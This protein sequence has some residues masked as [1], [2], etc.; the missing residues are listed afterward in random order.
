MS[1][2]LIID[3]AAGTDI[4]IETALRLGRMS[5]IQQAD[6]EI[7]ILYADIKAAEERIAYYRKDRE[8]C[9]ESLKI[10]DQRLA[11]MEE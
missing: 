7:P 8:W 2:E 6:Y 5:R 10:L 4:E 1:A 11:E 3:A 9:L